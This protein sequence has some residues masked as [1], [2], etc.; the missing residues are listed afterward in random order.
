MEVKKTKTFFTVTFLAKST[1]RKEFKFSGVRKIRNISA[2]ES[3][4]GKQY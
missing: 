3:E 4:L 1:L 2:K